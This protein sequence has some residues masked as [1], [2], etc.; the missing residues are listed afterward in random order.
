MSLLLV[1]ADSVHR[2]GAKVMISAVEDA[3]MQM[4]K[5]PPISSAMSIIETVW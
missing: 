4:L 3:G 1:K 5:M 2:H